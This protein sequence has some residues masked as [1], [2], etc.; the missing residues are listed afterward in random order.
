MRKLLSVSVCLFV[1][2]LFVAEAPALDIQ[3]APS[4]ISIHSSGG[5]FSIHTDIPYGF[6]VGP[7]AAV[8]VSVAINGEPLVCGKKPDLSG[9]LVLKASLK[10]VKDMLDPEAKSAEVT[11]TAE[12]PE[13][14]QYD[15]TVT[16]TVKVVNV[17]GKK[18][19]N[20]KK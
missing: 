10:T 14:P 19:Q 2:V 12:A 20:N 4:T 1:L 18:N 9:D 16:E 7:E 5:S 11:V 6:V 17:S 8:E 15:D 3:V 13:F